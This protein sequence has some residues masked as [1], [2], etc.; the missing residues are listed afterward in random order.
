MRQE[1]RPADIVVW[2]SLALKLALAG[3]VAS[4]VFINTGFWAAAF[5][6]K[7]VAEVLATATVIGGVFTLLA[8]ATAIYCH[9][10]KLSRAG[11]S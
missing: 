10:Q 3:L 1:F 7:G 8:V 2:Q 6:A 9:I 4:A 11:R 5:G